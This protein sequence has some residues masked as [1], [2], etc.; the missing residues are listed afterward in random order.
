MILL[1]LLLPNCLG[2]AD[3]FVAKINKV[4]MIHFMMEDHSEVVPYPKDPMFIKDGNALF[5]TMP[6]LA[7]KFRRITLKLLDL[8]LPKRDFV[9]STDSYHPGSIKT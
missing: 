4:S 8:M 5:H 6:N 2:T 9:F 1:L 7:P 3:G